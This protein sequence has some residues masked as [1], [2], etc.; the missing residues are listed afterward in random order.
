V[1]DQAYA[2]GVRGKDAVPRHA[3]L[4]GA[5]PPHDLGQEEARAQVRSA[6]AYVDVLGAEKAV[7]TG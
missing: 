6:R 4:G 2:V 5:S 3:H 1:V 7:V